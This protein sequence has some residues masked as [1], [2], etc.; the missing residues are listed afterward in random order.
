MLLATEVLNF[1]SSERCG[2]LCQ[3]QEI[4]PQDHDTKNSTP[5]C[6]ETKT[7]CLKTSHA[8]TLAPNPSLKPFNMYCGNST[9]LT[10]H[11]TLQRLL[12]NATKIPLNRQKQTLLLQHLQWT[13]HTN[14][15]Q[16]GVCSL[17]HGLDRCS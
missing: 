11:K 9:S 1:I 10:L 6:L 2:H 17:V 12:K 5:D 13:C 8:W 7:T 4:R 3:D 16:V 15:G 14:M